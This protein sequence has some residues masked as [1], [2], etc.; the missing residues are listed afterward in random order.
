MLATPGK[1]AEVD[2]ITTEMNNTSNTST[3][4]SVGVLLDEISGSPETLVNNCQDPPGQI[5]SV[6]VR[7]RRFYLSNGPNCPVCRHIQVSVSGNAVAT[8]D[9][10]LGITVRGALVLEQQG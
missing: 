5:P 6:T 4:C 3:Q 9:E 10:M 7:G 8:K 1:L 2:S